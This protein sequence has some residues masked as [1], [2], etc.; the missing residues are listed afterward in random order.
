MSLPS[1]FSKS[2]KCLV[3]QIYTLQ[4]LGVFF[5]VPFTG[6]EWGLEGSAVWGGGVGGRREVGYDWYVLEEVKLMMGGWHKRKIFRFHAYLK[7]LASQQDYYRINI[8]S[9]FPGNNYYKFIR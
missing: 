8:R 6:N 1:N 7:M 2:A 5:Y 4:C 3:F 9:D